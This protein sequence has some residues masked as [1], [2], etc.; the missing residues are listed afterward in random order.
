MDE[1]KNILRGFN[2]SCQVKLNDINNQVNI[3]NLW[4]IDY[5]KGII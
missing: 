4:E 5:N 1:Y 2:D 3:N